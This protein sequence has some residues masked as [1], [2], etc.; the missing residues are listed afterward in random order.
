MKSVFSKLLLSF[1]IIIAL[2]GLLV[3]ICFLQLSI[4][5]KLVTNTASLNAVLSNLA[6]H[7]E[8]LKSALS[9]SD[10][11]KLSNVSQSLKADFS[12]FEKILNTAKLSRKLKEAV[13][14]L[15]N[16]TSQIFQHI[17]NTNTYESD[18]INEFIKM[19][20]ENNKLALALLDELAYEQSSNLKRTRFLIILIASI[21]TVLS[22]VITFIT[23]RNFTNPIAALNVLVEN[24]SK[25]VLNVK[26]SEVSSQD[27]I[28][29]MARSV[30]KLRGDLLD[31]LTTINNASSNLASTSEELSASAEELSA[32][33]NS[34]AQSLNKISREA[35][36]NS[37]TVQEINATIEELSSTSQT[38]AEA[39]QRMLAASEKISDHLVRNTEQLSKVIDKVKN[40]EE[41]ISKVYS[42][43]KELNEYSRNIGQ[44]LDTI[45]SIAEQTNLLALNAAIEAARAGEA[46]RGF[47]V[48]ADEIRKLAEESRQATSKIGNILVSIKTSVENA[49]K[50]VSDSFTMVNDVSR[51]TY[52]TLES[53][54][55]LEEE[56]KNLQQHVQSV[57]ASSQQQSAAI[58]EISAGMNK[59]ANLIDLSSREIESLNAS[60]EEANAAIEELASASQNVANSAQV[61]QSKIDYFKI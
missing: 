34:L 15:K 10:T 57:A 39:A 32:T 53:Y 54:K 13:N 56:I 3:L 9:T 28:G 45:T 31:I 5:E 48:V 4:I 11:N 36:D 55:I 21:I 1:G 33:I 27:E 12:E 49:D 37:A 24:L 40:T 8:S 29:K 19:I 52:E 16:S 60:L 6:V 58:Q 47:A 61:L 2:L 26:M 20:D 41:S 22:V 14:N 30:E 43:M 23:S 42:T 50:I 59:I 18:K 51:Y 35:S 7:L 17:D 25:G 46:G 38:N 44:I